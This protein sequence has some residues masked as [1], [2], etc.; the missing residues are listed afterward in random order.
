MIAAVDSRRLRRNFST[1]AD[2]YDHHAQVQKQ[3]VANLLNFIAPSCPEQGT[4]LDV[5]CGTGTLSYEL[6]RIHPQLQP[7]LSDIAHGMTLQ[8]RS[9]L[10]KALAVDAAAEALPFADYSLDMVCSSSVYQW[11]LD[12]PGAF[13]ESARI[14]HEGGLFA[15]ALFG[16][17][18]LRELK[19]AYREAARIHGGETGH[20]H[21]LPDM[22]TVEQALNAAGFVQI[23]LQR[24]ELVEYH[25]DVT[26]LLRS[27]KRI[28]AG[29]ASSRAPRGLASRS[30]LQKMTAIYRQRYGKNDQIPASYEVLFG[31]ATAPTR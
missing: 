9:R 7:V 18:T 30:Q 24:Q 12:L 3:V 29:N 28:G 16:K 19:T 15:F 20:L 1:S 31:M 27:L 13:A 6:C 4:F 26:D 25:R 10:S 17:N 23:E 11:V 5:G 21:E 2:S 22:A 14:L 8:G